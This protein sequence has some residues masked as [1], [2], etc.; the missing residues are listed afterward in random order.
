MI[1]NEKIR[2]VWDEAITVFRREQDNDVV[3]AFGNVADLAERAFEK[4]A[5]NLVDHPEFHIGASDFAQYVML[6]FT[7][8]FV[9][10][11]RNMVIP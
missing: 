3:A 2:K 5:L 8:E 1:K 6:R 4:A 7:A 10:N 9:E 11:A